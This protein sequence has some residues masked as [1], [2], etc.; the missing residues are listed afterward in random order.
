MRRAILLSGSF[1]V[2]NAL[3]THF[4]RSTASAQV[5]AGDPAVLWHEV[6]FAGEG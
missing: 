2:A 5:A 6:E 1:A 3:L 4:Y